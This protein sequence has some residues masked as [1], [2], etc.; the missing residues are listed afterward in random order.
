VELAAQTFLIC[1]FLSNR[2]PI[3][4]SG[5]QTFSDRINIL[6]KISRTDGDGQTT[7]TPWA[8][9]LIRQFINNFVE[10]SG[11]Y[12]GEDAKVMVS[13]VF[14]LNEQWAVKSAL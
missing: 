8:Q 14:N 13:A 3:L 1:V 12:P 6:R 10:T 5:C 9:D 4:L 7:S 11:M 2:I